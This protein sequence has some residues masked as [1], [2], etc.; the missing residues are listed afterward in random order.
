M[1]L[2]ES[3]PYQHVI[4]DEGQD[5]GIDVIDEADV[6]QQIKDIIT[7]TKPDSG[8]FYVFYDRLQMIQA[9][10]MP[11]FIEDADCKLTLYRNCRNTE[12]IATTSLRPVTVRKPLLLEGCVKGTPAKLRFCA[13]DESVLAQIDASI[14]ELKADGYSDIVILTCKTENGSV[15]ADKCK[16]GI[17]RNKYRFTTCR[18]FKGLEADAVI[19]IDVDG[20]TFNSKNVLIF[21]VGTSRARLKLDVITKLSDEDCVDILKNNLE[22]TAKIKKPKKERASALNAIGSVENL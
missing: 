2:A 8:T 12:N 9:A 17:Y 15:L 4:V 14:D 13:S 21:Y 7:D 6:L 10:H 11:R 16:D 20:S 5:F 19:L 18:K 1:Y 3:F 22:Y